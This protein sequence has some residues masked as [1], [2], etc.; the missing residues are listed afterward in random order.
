M[1][2]SLVL[3]AIF[4]VMTITN[5]HAQ[6]DTPASNAAPS[7]PNSSL[8]GPPT[9]QLYDQRSIYSE[10]VNATAPY[11]VAVGECYA[12]LEKLDNCNAGT[13]RIPRALGTTGMVKSLTVEKGVITVVPVAGNGITSEDT[14]IVT[15]TPQA[16]GTL[17]WTASGGGVSKGYAK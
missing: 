16:N 15:P 6:T 9:V 1:K 2:K 4:S 8:S 5:I 14:Y 11:R 13:N 12:L 10:V 17:V 7:T 3:A